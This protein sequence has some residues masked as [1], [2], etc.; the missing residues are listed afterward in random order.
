MKSIIFSII[1]AGNWA[2]IGNEKFKIKVKIPNNKIN[3]TNGITKIFAT[4]NKTGN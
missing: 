1:T 4:K 3:V 2:N